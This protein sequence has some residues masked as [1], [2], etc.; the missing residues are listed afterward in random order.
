[1]LIFPTF[2]TMIN[3]TILLQIKYKLG[4]IKETEG[5]RLLEIHK[6]L[7]GISDF[8]AS[9]KDAWL[10]GWG[11]EDFDYYD[12]AGQAGS[13]LKVGTD[14]FYQII[15]KE[16]DVKIEEIQ[17]EIFDLLKN[18]KSFKQELVTELSPIRDK[19]EFHNEIDLLQKIEDYEWGFHISTVLRQMQ[20][21]SIAIRNVNL[22]N[23]GL[24]TPPHIHVSADLV[25]STTQAFSA[26]G[27]LELATRLLRQ[28][29]IKTERVDSPDTSKHN[30]LILTNIFDN[31]HNF[32]NQLK[33]RHNN[34]PSIEVNDE[35]D[36]QDILHS[37]LKL[38]FRDIRE[39]ENGPS[40]AG[41]SARMDFLLNEEQIVIE[42]KKT[43][44]KLTDRE[45]GNQ[46]ILDVSHYANHPSCKRLICF[47]YD[48]ENRVKNPRGVEKDIESRSTE[49]LNVKLYIRP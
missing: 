3:K 30:E 6:I 32:C 12:Y 46:L 19:E 14:Y 42:V 43:R 45:I 47:V 8:S 48:P 26:S 34:R 15:E 28:V 13:A 5:S 29:E 36:V 7:M 16:Y 20:P 10:G 38:H 40:F 24:A 9:F 25:A 2:G 35:Y 41:S 17:S 23:R 22:I 39:E 49:T 37:I 1:M 21:N 18:L 44:E 27:F 31:F 33:N 11:Q 4:Q